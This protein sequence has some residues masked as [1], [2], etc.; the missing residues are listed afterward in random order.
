MDL[1]D[2]G[3][4]GELADLGFSGAPGARGHGLGSV[5]GAGH[6]EV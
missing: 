3:S 6:R 1:E 5:V 2:R 4:C